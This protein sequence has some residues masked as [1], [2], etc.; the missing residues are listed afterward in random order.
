MTSNSVGVLA[1]TINIGVPY[2]LFY[3]GRI[4]RFCRQ[5]FAAHV[6]PVVLI[7]V[8]FSFSQSMFE[9]PIMFMFLFRFHEGNL[10]TARGSKVSVDNLGP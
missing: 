2:M 4:A 7:L 6:V 3:V 5:Y 8:I 9:F 10:S 1:S